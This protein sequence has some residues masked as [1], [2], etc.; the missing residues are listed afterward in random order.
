MT[1]RLVTWQTAA[2]RLSSV[3]RAVFIDEQRVPEAL[4]WDSEDE[5]CVH[6]LAES[7]SGMPVGTARLLEDG[8]VGRMAVL[9]PWRG[10]GVASALL[11]ALLA[12]AE[13]RGHC[14]VRLNAQ[15]QAVPF[16]ERFGFTAHGDVFDD[17]GIP[18][19]AMS[20]SVGQHR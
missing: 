7:S 6:A 10:K 9:A 13:R 12:E 4:E 3:R 15:L 1:V 8:H 14:H 16:Y 11:R 2:Q 5:T 18:H 17:A 19:R 20:L